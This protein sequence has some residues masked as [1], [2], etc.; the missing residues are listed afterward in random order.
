[1]T[2]PFALIYAGMQR[3]PRLASGLREALPM[4]RTCLLCALV[5]GCSGPDL[6]AAASPDASIMSADSGICETTCEGRHCGT[7]ACGRS[8]GSCAAGE[9]CDSQGQCKQRC[10]C[11]GGDCSNC[12]CGAAI[13]DHAQAAG[14]AV[15]DYVGHEGDLF[16]CSGGTFSLGTHC[17]SG[18][19]IVRPVG[20]PDVCMPLPGTSTYKL[21]YTCGSTVVTYVNLQLTCAGTPWHS[22]IDHYAIDFT[23]QPRNTPIVAAHAG[24]VMYAKNDIRPG[25]PCYNGPSGTCRDCNQ[26]NYVVVR[27]DDGTRALYL[28]LESVSVSVDQT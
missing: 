13:R 17:E 4:W 25:N 22:A 24:V 8:C 1:R 12:Y 26:A 11:W 21:P 15:D 3:A 7:D 23:G 16:N 14:C 9:A 6:Y 20:Q 18:Q 28:H 2:D 27:H 10:S 5:V 19:C